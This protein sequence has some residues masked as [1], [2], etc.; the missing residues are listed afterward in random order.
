MKKPI[1]R[2]LV[3]I[4]LALSLVFGSY[5]AYLYL[6]LIPHHYRIGASYMTMNNAFY[7]IVNAEIEKVTDAKGDHI[8]VRDPA[9]NVSKQCQQIESF[10]SKKVDAIIINPVSNSPKILKILKKAKAKGIKIIVI[11]SQL[12]DSHLAD[13]TIVSDNYQAGVL[14]AQNMMQTTS[15]AKILLLKHS[16][17]FSARDRIK[18][19]LDTI[20]NK[21]N[22]QV[23]AEEETLGQTEIAMPEVKKVIQAGITFNVVMALNDQSALGALAAI[24][25][26][27]LPGKTYIYG[28]DGSPNMKMLLTNTSD[29]QATVAQSPLT[30]GKKAI[31]KTYDLLHKKQTKKQ[32]V[33]PVQLIDKSTIHQFDT[34]R[35]Q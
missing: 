5:F 23:V 34:T 21:P 11:D 10:I 20:A 6:A 2:Q 1:L 13:M 28:V 16:Q 19:F 35:W 8:Y 15:Q 32:V 31:D 26:Q 27:A 25:E 17:A 12:K 7:R 4:L 24:K 30:I 18:G 22:Y 29:I 9:L 33:V 14:C 3:V